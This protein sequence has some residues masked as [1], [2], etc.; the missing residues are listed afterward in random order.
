M[1]EYPSDYHSGLREG[2]LRSA[3]EIVP[4]V[5]EFVRPASV[6]DVGCGSGA[7][8]SVFQEQGVGDVCGVDADWVDR[9]SLLFPPDRFIA[10]DLEKPLQLDRRFD[11]VVSLEVAEHLIPESA[12]SFVDSLVRLGPVLLFSAAVPFQGGTNHFNEQWPGYWAAY[13][14]QRG[15]VDIDCLRH[16]IWDNERVEWWYAQNVLFFVRKDRLAL[17]PALQ[18]KHQP[19]AP[20]PLSLVHP[21]AV[22]GQQNQRQQR[23]VELSECIAKLTNEVEVLRRRV[24]ELDEEC[25]ARRT[26]KPR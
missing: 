18:A 20:R 23:E 7:W 3:R 15:Y 19:D 9:D 25:R 16:S 2:A 14:A 8:L 12:Q 5:M 10:A 1:T 11:L 22:M 6:V 24:T 4:L 26:A 17:Y 21:R 13:F